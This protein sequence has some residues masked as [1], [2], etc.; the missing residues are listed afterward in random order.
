AIFKSGMRNGVS[1]P[2][3][4]ITKNRIRPDPTPFHTP[5][6]IPLKI[7]PRALPAH[8]AD[9]GAIF[10]RCG[11][12]PCPPFNPCR[13]G[14]SRGGFFRPQV[15]MNP[16]AALSRP[17]LFHT[18]PVLALYAAALLFAPQPVRAQTVDTLEVFVLYIEFEDEGDAGDEPTTT[19]R[20]VFGSDPDRSYKLDPNGQSFRRS[21]YYLTVRFEGVHNYSDQASGGRVVIRPRI[22]PPPDA[23]D[24][25]ITPL[26]LGQ[27]MK[28]YNPAF[29]DKDA[30]Q[31]TSD[32]SLQRA[33]ALMRFVSETAAATKKEPEA[34]NA[35]KT[36][37]TAAAANPSPN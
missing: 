17:L 1:A 19:G 22:F 32:F 8:R 10:G 5:D 26:K 30:K 13:A 9:P 29:E 33:I 28:A 36:A 16:V 23:T 27:R 14:V 7:G 3:A 21:A 6:A 2:T 24:S 25:L 15:P 12:V 4:T 11:F 18:L 37:F 31:K 35:F 20:G 34:S